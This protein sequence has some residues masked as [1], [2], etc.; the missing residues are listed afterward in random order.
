MSQGTQTDRRVG[1]WSAICVAA[2][3]GVYVSVGGIG[4]I[5]RPPGL[6][7]LAQVDP[8]LAILEFLIILSAV[9]LVTMMAAVHTWSP[10][11]KKTFSLIA[12]AFMIA[13]AILTC[14][15]HF[16]SLTVG[17]Q[18][19]SGTMPQFSHQLSFSWPTIALALDLLAWDLFLGLSL[20]FAALVFQGDRQQN[21]LRIAMF[22]DATLCLA[23]TAGPLS[24]H[25]WLQ[26]SAITGYAVVLPLVC[27]L[28]A[29]LFA[30]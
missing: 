25:M 20:L 21:T 12:F 17:R 3:G 24:G 11:E 5:M 28:V 26:L 2:L 22:V 8:Y 9:A 10:P 14:S 18:I 23:G 29:R 16:A 1:M 30:R 4:V 13:F 6:A 7:P 27:I 19:V 15:T